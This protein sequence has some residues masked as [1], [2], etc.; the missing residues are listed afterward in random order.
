MSNDLS[1]RLS[2]VIKHL[3]QELSR[4]RTGRASA[5]LVDH[6]TVQAYGSPTP[7]KHMAQI[8]VQDAQSLVIQPFDPS[9]THAIEKAF[10][11]SNLGLNPTVDGNVL[12]VK[13]PPM[14]EERRKEL[15]H[16]LHG[17]AE[18]ARVSVRNVREEEIKRLK[19]DA[20]VS[21]DDRR[22]GTASI[23]KEID[24]ANGNIQEIVKAKEQEVMTV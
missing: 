9:T 4:L 20:S 7:L 6:L 10:Q 3:Q 12:R 1:S 2:A 17:K 22:S 21:D 11:E 15:V 18:E 16:V 13:I 23:Q 5:E 24:S 8:S 19:G 14:S